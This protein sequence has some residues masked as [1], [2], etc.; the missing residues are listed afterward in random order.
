MSQRNKIL[1]LSNIKDEVKSFHPILETLFKKLPRIKRVDYTHGVNE[2]G[3]DFVLSRRDDTL[4]VDEYIGVIVKLGKIHQD[5]GKIRE[6]IEE[7]NL[8]RY[9]NNGKQRVRL[10]EIWI[11]TNEHITEGAKNKIYDSFS[12]RKIKFIQHTDLI[13]LIDSHLENFWY[14]IPL[15]ISEY[16]NQQ[17]T[18]ITNLENAYNLIPNQQD[19]FYI[20]QDIQEFSWDQKYDTKSKNKSNSKKIKKE[21]IIDIIL[22]NSILLIEGKPGYGKSKLVRFAV[23]YFSNPTNFIRYKLL[24]VFTSYRE[25]VD[26]YEGDINKFVSS[27]PNIKVDSS[28]YSL[29]IFIDG[30]DE[31]LYKS[32]EELEKFIA[33]IKNL[34][35]IKNSKA[36]VT[37][38]SLNHLDTKQLQQLNIKWY[39]ILPLSLQKILSFFDSL[40]KQS[41]IS[42]RIVQDIRKSHLFQQLPKSPIAAILLANLL[43]ENSKELPSNLT[44]LYSKYSELMLGRWD[45][46]KGLQSQK[47]FEAA[48][49]IIMNIAHYFIKNNLDYLALDEAKGFFYSYFSKRN[50][51]INPDEL[52]EKLTCRSGIIQRQDSLNRVFFKHRTFAEF[53]FASNS[54][55][56]RPAGFISGDVY[57]NYWR[58][59][60]FFYIGLQK[61]CEIELQNIIDQIPDSDVQ[62]FTRLIYLSDYFLAGYATPYN[63][64]SDNLPIIIKEASTL[65]LDIVN[66]KIDLPLNKLPKV[67]LLYI[68]QAIMRQSYSFEFFYP[69][70]EDSIINILNDDNISTEEK[71]YSLFF[72]SVILIDL[73]KENPFDGLIENLMDDLPLSIQFGIMYESDKLKEHSK[74]L[75]KQDRK[76]KRTMKHASNSVKSFIDKI[77][78]KP[79]KQL[80]KKAP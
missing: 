79:V 49:S 6:Q 72:I 56:K 25:L 45:M 26:E 77:H 62:K 60:F 59:V 53:F 55:K 52:F 47:E 43:E 22:N 20:E 19:S 61:D 69:A 11:L 4:S 16:L 67:S 71:S 9:F 64:V 32:E 38:R 41:R 15:G 29:A 21:K 68:F 66:G 63:I 8:G 73:G 54:V 42:D 35:T 12:S 3:A 74:I 76:L 80:S 1:V 40:C 13:S 36:I 58:N 34:K 39:E 33:L 48:T 51:G 5:L 75:K 14:D 57:S 44:E 27:K 28:D 7:C 50:L 24:P 30:Y 37:S 31:K 78:S 46:N 2:A 18:E 65:F 70:L 10:D 17:N 23:S